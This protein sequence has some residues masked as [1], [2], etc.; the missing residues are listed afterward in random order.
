MKQRAIVTGGAG[1]IGSYVVNALVA[2]GYDVVV[3]DNLSTGK[4]SNVNEKATLEVCDICEYEAIIPLFKKDDIVFHLAALVSVPLSIENPL[5]SNEINIKGTYNVLEACRVSGAKGVVITSSAAV[6]GNQEGAVTEEAPTSPQT[7][8]AL[9]KK[10]AEELGSLYADLYA[11]PVVALRY[12]NVYG[13]GHH[14]EGSYAPVIARFLKQ[15]KDGLPFSL[16]DDGTQT[17]DFIHVRDVALANIACIPHLN[18]PGFSI[19]NVSSNTNVSV[20]EIA[21]MIDSSRQ[22]T[23]LPPRVEVKHSQGDNT[24]IKNQL[25]WNPTVELLDGITELL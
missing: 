18:K 12:F 17:R 1:F 3:I 25:R 19:F 21:Q 24:K 6:Y 13:K 16:V 2:T 23:S 11:L 7:P 4:K 20:K 5:L 22:Q 10:F 15:K 9:Q 8:Y 14:E